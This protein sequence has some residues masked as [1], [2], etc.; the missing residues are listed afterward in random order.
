MRYGKKSKEVVYI[1]VI[2]T[3][4]TKVQEKHRIFKTFSLRVCLCDE[5][6]H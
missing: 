4:G 1:W 6:N 5:T 2:M 3:P